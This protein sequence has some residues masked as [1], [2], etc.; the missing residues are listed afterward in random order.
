MGRGP[1]YTLK[2]AARYCGYSSASHFRELVKQYQLPAKGPNGNRYA[3][4][5]LDIFMDNCRAFLDALPQRPPAARSKR[6]HL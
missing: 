5:D 4:A 6:L 3:E 1:Y 2:Q